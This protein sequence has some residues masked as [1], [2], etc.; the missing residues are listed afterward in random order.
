[1][2]FAGVQYLMLR[3][4]GSP[5]AGYYPNL[6]DKPEPVEGVDAAFTDFVLS[7]VDELVEIGRTRYTQTNECRRCT[8]LLPAVWATGVTRFH[9][10]D[11]GTSAGLNLL[12]DRYR[13]RWGGTVWGPTDSAV[14]LETEMRGAGVTPH[15]IDVVSRT[16][17]DVNPLDP[18]DS[19]DRRWLEAL[20]WPEHSD[21]R[22]RLT[23]ALQIA[24]TNP[25]DRVAGDGL[26]TL[27]RVLEGL[28]GDDSVVV[29][30]SFILN[31]FSPG[32]RVRYQQILA[33]ARRKRLV[34]QVSMEWLDQ[35]AEAADLEIDVGSG[36]RRIGRAQPHGEW[37]ELI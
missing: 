13:Y 16:G 35:S 33:E 9:L 15:E 21:R 36:L 14:E 12:L 19:D 7:N 10:V 5:L 8:A 23:W 6:T 30:N 31:Q 3:D 22:S 18:S 28:A 34:I 1:M 25:I 20:V 17:L 24:A 32:D 26:A 4:G 27:P 11:F 37:L 2:L 29:V